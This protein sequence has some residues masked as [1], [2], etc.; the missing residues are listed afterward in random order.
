[1]IIRQRLNFI[2]LLACMIA[3][4]YTSFDLRGTRA[5][6]AQL[7]TIFFTGVCGGALL[8]VFI[9]GFKK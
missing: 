6:M 8:V 3:G 2:S 7:L 9:R 4:I 5:G 1:M